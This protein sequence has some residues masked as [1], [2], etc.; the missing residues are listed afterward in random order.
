M[1]FKMVCPKCGSL[2]YSVERDGRSYIRTGPSSELI[3]SCRC[4]KQMFG[5]QLTEEFERQRSAYEAQA[6]ERMA[7]EREREERVAAER[8]RDEKMRKAMEFRQNY[9]RERRAIEEEEARAAKEDADRRWRERVATDEDDEDHDHDH[10]HGDHSHSTPSRSAF[11]VV[12]VG[13]DEDPGLDEEGL[14]Y[15]P[16]TPPNKG[17]HLCGWGPCV[18][19]ARS[20]SKYCSRACSNKNAR[21]RHKQRKK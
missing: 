13:G 14:P 6:E 18:N 3:F 7:A 15:P 9:L 20:N 8:E 4:G 11:T 5:D 16:G 12:A 17:H 19:E 1:A 21:W 10:D 2:N